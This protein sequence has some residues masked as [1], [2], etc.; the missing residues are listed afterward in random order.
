MENG[1]TG[2]FRI[3]FSYPREMLEEGLRRLN[4]TLTEIKD[5]DIDEEG[6]EGGNLPG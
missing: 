1:E 2:W 6:F 5:G 3:T 4:K